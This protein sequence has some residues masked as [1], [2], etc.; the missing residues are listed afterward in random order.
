MFDKIVFD[1]AGVDNFKK[2]LDVA[3]YRHKLISGNVANSTTPGYKAKDIDFKDEIAK[4]IG[5]GKTLPL[6]TTNA[7]H[8]GN[9]GP[10]RNIKVVETG[11][12]APDD[13]NGVDVDKEMTNLAVNQM[14][15]SISARL[16]QQKFSNLRKAI[17]GRG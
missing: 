9:T 11:K 15:Y 8:I 14:R 7:G 2:L 5:G 4:A 16:L 17:T 10:R 13:L 1:R 12:K 6:T 3:A